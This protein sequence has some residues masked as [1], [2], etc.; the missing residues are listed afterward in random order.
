[1]IAK[2]LGSASVRP[3]ILSVLAR[4]DSY[5]YQIIQFAHDFSDG[6]LDLKPGV[7]YP[8]LRRME[9]D[10]LIDGYWQHVEGERKRRY[11]RL[12]TSGLAALTVEKREWLRMHEAFLLLWKTANI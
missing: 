3:L 8:I 7:L 9:N 6:S 2:A 4:Q 1:M 11:Y 12:T 5:G 10:G